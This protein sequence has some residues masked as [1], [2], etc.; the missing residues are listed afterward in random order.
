MERNLVMYEYKCRDCGSLLLLEREKD[1]ECCP[2]CEGYN[3]D[4]APGRI[5]PVL[6]YKP[7]LEGA[8]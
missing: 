7:R 3:I 5:E 8:E 4:Y 6:I 1:P 2:Y